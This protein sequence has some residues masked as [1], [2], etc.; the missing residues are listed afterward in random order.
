MKPS[1]QALVETGNRLNDELT[2]LLIDTS[3]DNHLAVISLPLH[4][5]PPI[6]S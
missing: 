6:I 4:N 1:I 3:E 2:W 5:I